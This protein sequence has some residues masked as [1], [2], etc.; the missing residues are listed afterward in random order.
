MILMS[1]FRGLRRLA[2]VAILP[3]LLW[4]PACAPPAGL[5]AGDATPADQHQ[6][7]FRDED[8]RTTRPGDSSAA[9]ENRLRP[10][11]ELPF[12]EPQNLP[13][14]TL[15]T[16]RLKNPISAENPGASGAF[17]AIVDQRVAVDG[18]TVIPAG[19]TVSGRVES[20]RASDL[21]RNLGYVRLTLMSIRLAGSDVP[22]QTS[23]LF[24]RAGQ[25]RSKQTE[26]SPAETSTR[27]IR[28]EKGRRLVFRLSEPVFVAATHRVPADH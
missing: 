12:Q 22:V 2:A 26:D 18:N 15:L 23:S 4:V 14:G 20:A 1:R 17:E 6:V 16:V 9:Q 19:A 5:Q 10:E 3:V 28:I 7:P 21:K 8:G 24:V 25:S 11:T 27:V 13:A